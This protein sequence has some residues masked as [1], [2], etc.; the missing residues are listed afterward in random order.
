MSE[1]S[2]R[3]EQPTRP[4]E[5]AA[6]AGAERA[7]EGESAAPDIPRSAL[8]LVIRRAVELSLTERD[9][10]ER[11]SEEEVVRVATEVGL[12]AHLARQ[13]LY[14]RPILDSA[15]GPF[16]RWF[17]GGIVSASRTIPAA[18][19][20]RLRRRLEDYLGGHEYLQ[21][22]R[23]RGGR[24]FFVPAD[25][26]I[27]TL[28]RGLF[29]PSRRYQLARARRVLVDV[30]ALDENASHV[31]IATDFSQQRRSAAKTAVGAGGILALA[32]GGVSAAV[33]ASGAPPG[34]LGTIGEVGAFLGM[35]GASLAGIVRLA[36]RNFR[37]R[38]L[39]AKTELDG[40][41]DRAEH[42][43]RLEPPPAPWRRR[44]QQR[45]GGG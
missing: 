27:S 34:V 39:E 12:P 42:G 38:M 25:D 40:L 23:R 9:S 37:N 13:A 16:D 2:D 24:L 17:G 15:S 29:R 30:R 43:E 20:D 45:L 44:L 7:P 35:S 26:A 28:A 10:Q 1:G 18:D 19:A 21:L 33:V 36:G 14:E 22:V 41:L 6:P 3:R 32:I 11:L 4:T 31:Q 5:P 8:E